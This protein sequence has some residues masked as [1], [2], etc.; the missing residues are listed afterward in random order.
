MVKIK[1]NNLTISLRKATG[2]TQ[3]SS[4][5]ATGWLFSQ[6]FAGHKEKHIILKVLKEKT[7][8]TTTTK[9]KTQPKILCL[10]SLPFNIVG[11]IGLQ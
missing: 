2:Y 4:H 11:L 1:I 5:K 8:I 10:T 6:N 7:T 9:P 3:G